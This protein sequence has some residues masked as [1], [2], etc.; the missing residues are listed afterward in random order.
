[1][2]QTLV[3]IAGGIAGAV[4]T[5]LLHKYGLSVVVAAC[6]IGLHGAALEY[7][8]KIHHF[9][10]VIFAG[11]FVGMTSS[12]VASLPLIILGGALAGFLYQQSTDLFKGF[13]GRLGTIAFISTIA[14]YY[15]LILVKKLV[16]KAK[17]AS[18][19]K[20]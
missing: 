5:Y 17:L 10:F 7:F 6:I 18:Y 15:F 13:G 2:P 11:A 9:S 3:F 14:A 4:A 20:G 8:F 16:V 19:F 1:M 12:S